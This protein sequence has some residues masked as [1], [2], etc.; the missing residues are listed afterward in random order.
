[1]SEKRVYGPGGMLVEYRGMGTVTLGPYEEAIKTG[2][3]GGVTEEKP[4]TY[5]LLPGQTLVA[6]NKKPQTVERHVEAAADDMFPFNFDVSLVYKAKDIN[7]LIKNAPLDLNETLE[8]LLEA[9]AK[10]AIYSQDKMED[11]LKNRGEIEKEIKNYL[12]GFLDDWGLGIEQVRTNISVPKEYSD[13]FF[14]L[15]KGEMKKSLAHI[16][17]EIKRILAEYDT[18][19][20]AYSR[21]TLGK[22]EIMLKKLELEVYEKYQDITTNYML[23][24]ARELKDIFGTTQGAL[25]FDVYLSRSGGGNYT[26]EKTISEQLGYA[27]KVGIITDTA[28]KMKLTPYDLLYFEAVRGSN[29]L[30]INPGLSASITDPEY[31]KRSDQKKTERN[32]S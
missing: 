10:K 15:G 11:A 1:M 14:D 4:G 20:K 18:K 28:E 17:G 29:S 26:L 22:V 30:I 25:A 32:F 27:S 13:L 3:F 16:E 12:G 24:T 5:F 9:E 23:K 2:I 8:R 19:I 21:E 7:K 6:V 31:L